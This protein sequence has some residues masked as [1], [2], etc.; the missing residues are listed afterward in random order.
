MMKKLRLSFLSALLLL[1]AFVT[2]APHFSTWDSGIYDATVDIEMVSLS[3]TP[4]GN[5]LHGDAEITLKFPTAT[6]PRGETTYVGTARLTAKCIAPLCG[7]WLVRGQTEFAEVTPT[8]PGDA[9]GQ[10]TF[11]GEFT[12]II[13]RGEVVGFEDGHGISLRARI[14][15]LVTKPT[16]P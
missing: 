13:E 15:T 3:L 5:A 4:R 6:D 1:V 8:G 12:P 11:S 10:G 2:M 14:A 16:R 7:G 9:Q